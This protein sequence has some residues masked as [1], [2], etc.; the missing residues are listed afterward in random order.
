MDRTDPICLTR[1]TRR[2]T[3]RPVVIAGQAWRPR[4]RVHVSGVRTD[5]FKASSATAI[6]IAHPPIHAT[7]LHGR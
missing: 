3:R 1:M 4:L 5:S 6:L 2:R 7:A